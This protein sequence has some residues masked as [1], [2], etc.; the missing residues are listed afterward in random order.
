MMTIVER[1]GRLGLAG[2]AA[3]WLIVMAPGCGE[4]EEGERYGRRDVTI[5][6]VPDNVMKAA[7]GALPEIDF[8]EAWANLGKG[9]ELL[10]YEVR[11]RA[12]NGKMREVRVGL[13]GT[14]L[15]KE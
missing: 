11:G 13:D 15:E 4:S 2:F 12:R 8:D 9:G 5:Q 1:F 14:I 10:S 6:D 7:K 3:L